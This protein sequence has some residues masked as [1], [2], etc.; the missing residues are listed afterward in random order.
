MRLSFK[1]ALCAF[2]LAIGLGS[3]SLFATIGFK[4]LTESIKSNGMGGTAAAC[5]H[6][7]LTVAT[8]PANLSWIGTRLDIA[9]GL[10]IP[11]RHYSYTGFGGDSVKSG[12]NLFFIPGTGISYVFNDFISVG[13]TIYAAAGGNTTYHK[14]NPAMGY[15]K[16]FGRSLTTVIVAN[17][18]SVKYCDNFSLGFSV[19][20]GAQ[21]YKVNGHQNIRMMSVSPKNVSNNGFGYSPYGLG[22]RVGVLWKPTPCVNI[23]ASYSPRMHFHQI[24][25]YSGILNE[26]GHHDYP[27]LI[28]AGIQWYA[29]KG[30]TFAFD[31][32]HVGFRAPPAIGSSFG[33][34]GKHLFGS[35]KGPAC[36][37]HNVSVYKLG[38]EKNI[39]CC[40][41]VRAGLAFGEKPYGRKQIDPNIGSPVLTRNHI[42]LGGTYRRWG[43]E[44]DF[45]YWHGLY[46]S[47]T[48]ES[49]I[50]L[51]TVKESML[52]HF[53]GLNI[54]KV[55]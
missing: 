1:N 40:L 6:D 44:F 25:K 29:G 7:T 27:Q 48:G 39:N 30:F 32:E 13:A 53:I 11:P 28:E 49:M 2:T 12:T 14:P 52:Q 21:R 3:G 20:V 31:Y 18:I 37:W 46:E 26:K 51:G 34:L 42:T 19:L 5:P 16:L 36:G 23:G 35:P 15:G 45:A 17:T 22:C 33:N 10:L 8:N 38:V 4:P 54:G 55:F 41:D 9:A 50:G 24:R 43:F 47:I